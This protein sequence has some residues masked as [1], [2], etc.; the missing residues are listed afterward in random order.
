ML[1]GAVA[2]NAWV[3]YV[4]MYESPAVWL[5]S[6]AM[7]TPVGR[8]LSE[9]G[10]QALLPEQLFLAVPRSFWEDTDNPDVLRFFWPRG[11]KVGVYDD[12]VPLAQRADAYLL[13]NDAG[14]WRLAAAEDP[15]NAPA[16]ARALA[17]Q[18]RLRER[19]GSASP[20][21]VVVGP[22]FPGTNVPTF[23]LYHRPR[24]PSPR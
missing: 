4:R 5:A 12:L 22:P 24:E 23:W 18:A 13:P 16:A 20:D 14:L 21:P 2:W 9:L 17:A 10:R 19:L 1:A 6:S 8:R 3:Y 15:A 11:L 7:G